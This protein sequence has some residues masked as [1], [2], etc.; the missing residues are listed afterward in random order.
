MKS[1]NIAVV[2]DRKKVADN[3][4]I[5]GLVQIRI[6]YDRQSWYL[7]TSIK[8][9]KSQWNAS[10]CQVQNIDTTGVLTRQYNDRIALLLS[11]ITEWDN[12]RI[13]NGHAFDIASLKRCM[14]GKTSEN[15]IAFCCG[16][17][18]S[19][20]EVKRSDTTRTHASI[21][22]IIER[23]G[24]FPTFADI[25]LENIMRFDSW[26]KTQGYSQN[27]VW[28]KHKT[29]KMFVNEAVRRGILKESPY[30]TF[31]T[32]RGKGKEGRPLTQQ[33]MALILAASLP[34]ALDTV[35]DIM[36][37]QYNTGLAYADL[38]S[39]DFRDTTDINGRKMLVQ[40]RRKTGVKY[41]VP[42]LK[43]ADDVLSRYGYVLPKM[44][45]QQL[46]QRYKLVAMYAGLKDSERLCTHDL[47]KGAASRLLN[48]GVRM[49]VISKY[50]GHSSIRET[51]SLYARM[52]ADTVAEEVSAAL[53]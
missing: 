32:T 21:I 11:R 53:E 31:K 42:I 44:S 45:L 29:M 7:S 51:E 2:F 38:M 33:D 6:T 20:R 12:K 10:L 18:S 50:M 25:T 19:E 9:L 28:S 22:K 49:E 26:L 14:E 46:N 3:R 47:R 23:S 43:E 41:Y 13:G 52:T 48:M 34:K 24:F 27:T 36:I 4:K 15:F 5:R 16:I 40:R 37:V 39:V 8:V 35:R 30:A 17:V 1:L